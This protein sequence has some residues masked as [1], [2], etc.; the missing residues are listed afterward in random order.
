M[1]GFTYKAMV[2][3]KWVPLNTSLIPEDSQAFI[4]NK[5]FDA[6]KQQAQD[7][8]DIVQTM[9]DN[10]WKRANNPNDSFDIGD[11]GL[12][13]MSLCSGMSSPLRRSANA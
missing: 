4:K 7:A 2:D 9:M 10:A 3:G 8:R 5:D 12:L 1:K 11:F 13:I 6:R